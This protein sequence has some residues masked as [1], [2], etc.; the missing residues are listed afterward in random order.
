MLLSC[1]LF[2]F[3]FIQVEKCRFFRALTYYF[4]K[5]I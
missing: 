2:K 4:S 1:E 3:L 5:N